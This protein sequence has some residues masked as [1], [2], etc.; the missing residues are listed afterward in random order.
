[1]RAS[2]HFQDPTHRAT[3][4][5]SEVLVDALRDERVSSF[6]VIV[7]FATADGLRA[8][9]DD[10]DFRNFAE[11]GS[12]RITVGVDAITLP[13]ALDVLAEAEVEFADFTA[14]VFDSPTR[15]LFHPKL[16]R[17]T[18]E[19]ESAVVIL[20]SG[21][22]TVGGLQGN[23]EAFVVIEL[24]PDEV[25]IA[26]DIDDFY[27]RHEDNLRNLDARAYELAD[28]N[29]RLI[30]LRERAT[31]VEPEDDAETE[32]TEAADQEQEVAEQR[33]PEPALQEPVLVAQVPRGESR[34]GQVGLNEA[35][36]DEF[37]DIVP[38][39]SQRLRLRHIQSDGVVGGAE[40]RA[41][42]MS[43]VNRNR[44][45][46]IGAAHGVPYP[47][48]GA[49]ILV[50]RERGVRQYDYM[51]VLPGELGHEELKRILET[52]PRLGRGDPRA[53]VTSEELAEEW[54]ESPLFEVD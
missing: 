19:D 5:L 53:V 35:V 23:F 10:P 45:L 7:A 17:L 48:N 13:E 46:E 39:S 8:I 43:E 47:S 28:A 22:L 1:V 2:V 41:I 29:R 40:I 9:V 21:N 54:P 16:F 30:R 36:V 14:E 3:A 24:D 25:G 32:A 18:R 38:N 31:E 4:Y 20:G 44:R 26:G 50:L 11:R 34:W 15:R 12:V 6:E 33:Q 49:P 52:R 42:R 27:Q 51:L 37:L